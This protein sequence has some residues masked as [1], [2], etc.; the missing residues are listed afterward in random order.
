MD[1]SFLKIMVVWGIIFFFVS[2][3]YAYSGGS[4]T[5]AEPYQIANAA[6]LLELAGDANDYDKCFILVSDINLAGYSFTNAVIAP[7][8]SWDY[9]FQGPVFE[10]VFDGD[11]HVITNLTIDPNTGY[12]FCVALFGRT[13]TNGVIKNLGIENADKLRC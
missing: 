9:D 2:G 10:G 6:D 1:T 4:G 7:D 8:I 12:Y 3:V 5:E 13:G 11:G